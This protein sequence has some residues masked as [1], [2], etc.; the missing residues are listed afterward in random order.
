MASKEKSFGCKN[1]SPGSFKEV[2]VLG[3]QSSRKCSRT[4]DKKEEGVKRGPRRGSFGDRPVRM[5]GSTPEEVK[6]LKLK[7]KRKKAIPRKGSGEKRGKGGLKG[8]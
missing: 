1:G 8:V 4:C 2:E 3:L 7:R 5:V 6:G